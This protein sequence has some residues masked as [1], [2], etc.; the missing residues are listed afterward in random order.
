MI[1]KIM[2][3]VSM[4]AIGPMMTFFWDK[5]MTPSRNKSTTPGRYLF[6]TGIVFLLAAA[7][8]FG[9]TIP[10]VVAAYGIYFVGMIWMLQRCYQEPMLIKTVAWV[11][12]MA[13]CIVGDTIFQAI[14]F[15]VFKEIPV[16]DYSQPKTA[17]CCVMAL[18]IALIL[19]IFAMIIW[20]KV[21]RKQ[22]SPGNMEKILLLC[23]LPMCIVLMG[24]IALSHASDTGS[25]PYVIAYSSLAFMSVMMIFVLFFQNDRAAVQKELAKIQHQSELERV[26]YAVVEEKREAL[27]RIR[28]D[29]QNVLNTALILMES[30]SQEK[31]RQLLIEL[32]ERISAT[33]ETPYCAI[34]VINAVLTEK[35]TVCGE[36]GILLRTELLLPEV[37]P[38]DDFSL[39]IIVGNLIDNA[40]HAC[41]L[42]QV[43][44]EAQARSEI[45]LSAGVVQGYLVI[46]CENPVFPETE[47]KKGTGYGQKIL[48]SLAEKYQG[49]F[50]SER[51]GGQYMAQISLLLDKEQ[52][53]KLG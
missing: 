33:S 1:Y 39:C 40:I 41:G 31:A 16:A 48:N 30:G 35:A 42:A 4:S 53:T 14:F 2:C 21:Y 29:Y 5:M 8:V 15:L 23:I 49:N 37:L 10:W 18:P 47:G 34:P 17:F 6:N 38:V 19:Y 46:K 27:A 9:G 25:S 28:H 3:L 44:R 45:R 24:V 13:L 20:N 52:P 32:T 36:Q 11:L 22:N 50:F 12:L 51:Q 26:H 43:E 7:R